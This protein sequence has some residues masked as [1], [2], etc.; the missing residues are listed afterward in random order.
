M[1]TLRLTF[2][3]TDHA[4]SF[5]FFVFLVLPIKLIDLS[6]TFFSEYG[7][8][9]V[10]AQQ[11]FSHN[12]RSSCVQECFHSIT[13]LYPE[14]MTSSTTYIQL[15]ALSDVRKRQS[16]TRPDFLFWLPFMLG[17]ILDTFKKVGNYF[18]FLRPKID[19]LF[20]YDNAQAR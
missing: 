18:Y 15:P 9:F 20:K 4:C 7:L 16:S 5:L 6:L 8:F 17:W 19:L 1:S 2:T 13:R 3:A 11:L 12:H 10:Q 14:L